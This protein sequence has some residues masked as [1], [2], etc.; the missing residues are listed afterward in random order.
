M[1]HFSFL[2]PTCLCVSVQGHGY[3]HSNSIQTQSS[4]FQEEMFHTPYQ[5]LPGTSGQKSIN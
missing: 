2:C 4:T 5:G 1:I 3:K